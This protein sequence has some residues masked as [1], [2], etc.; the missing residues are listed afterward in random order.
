MNGTILK[1][2][3]KKRFNLIDLLAILLVIA[4]AAGGVY[5]FSSQERGGGNYVDLEFT[6]LVKSIKSVQGSKVAV[7]DTVIETRE[8]CELG[9]VT[10]VSVSP[11]TLATVDRETGRIMNTP[12]PNMIAMEVTVSAKALKSGDV[13]TVNGVP[14]RVGEAIFFGVPNLRASGYIESMLLSTEES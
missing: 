3:K 13:Y 7:G 4:I 11:A 12:V 8:L 9:F 1:Q 2:K 10:G 5:Y 6:I 14:I